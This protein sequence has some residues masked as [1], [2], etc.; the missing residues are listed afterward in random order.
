MMKKIK[1]YLTFALLGLLLTF[2]MSTNSIRAEKK[3]TLQ[4]LI[5]ILEVGK[6]VSYGNLAI[7]PVYATRVK[8]KTEYMTLEDALNGKWIEITE[9][10]GGRV[11]QVKISNNSK[12]KIYIMG[13]EI[14]TGCKQDRILAQDVLL[15]PGTKNLLVPVY[16]VEHG[17]WSYNSSNFYS[18]KNI[19]TYQLRARAQEKSPAAQSEIWAQIENQNRKM[20]V[21]S[22]TG[23]YQDAFE[24]EENKDRIVQI[25]RKMRIVPRMYEDTIGVVVGLGN[26]IV[27]ADIFA[28]PDLFKKQWPKILKSSALSSISHGKRGTVSQK[29]AADFLKSLYV[30]KYERKPALDLGYELVSHDPAVNL[31][32]LVYKYSIIH[33]AGFPREDNN[34]G[35]SKRVNREQRLRVIRE[36]SQQVT[37]I[38]SIR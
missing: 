28:N 24:K 11:P 12:H 1:I 36:Q 18:K 3:G 8:D 33:L 10:E 37:G 15:A 34:S 14:L 25:E 4:D 9:I 2:G 35:I 31:G 26:R 19:G 27:S 23:A 7:I 16:C 13:G 22:K 6:P 17:R 5:K 32:A 21:S 20:G 30:M 29:D 38:S